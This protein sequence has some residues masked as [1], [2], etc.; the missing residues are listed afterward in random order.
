M[1][2]GEEEERGVSGDCHGK[3]RVHNYPT[4]TLKDYNY[5]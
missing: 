2:A 5:L 1:T 3:V 4:A